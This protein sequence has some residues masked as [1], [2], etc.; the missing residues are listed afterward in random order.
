MVIHGSLVDWRRGGVSL[1]WN[2][3]S[4]VVFH[5][6]MVNWRGLCS[7]QI[8]QVWC[9]SIPGISA[10][11][12]GSICHRSMLHHYTF[13]LAIDYRSMLHHHTLPLPINHR[14]I[15]LLHPRS[16]H[17]YL[18]IMLYVK[19]MWCSGLLWIYGQLEE[20]VGPIDHRYIL[21]HYAP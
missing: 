9:S 21:H 1:S 14:S 3:F 6:S 12:R 16:L 2:Q 5:G 18:C 4:V 11:V 13:L 10:Q 7:Q 8:C 17:K 15:L 20:G 19:L